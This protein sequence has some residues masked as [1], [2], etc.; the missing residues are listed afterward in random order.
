MSFR[1]GF[2]LVKLLV[3]MLFSLSPVAAQE[4]D[5]SWPGPF[6]TLTLSEPTLMAGLSI[7]SAGSYL[8]PL[9]DKTNEAAWPFDY[10]V[11]NQTDQVLFGT[12]PGAIKRIPP[13]T[14]V[15]PV[16][17]AGD[18]MNFAADVAASDYRTEEFFTFVPTDGLLGLSTEL[19]NTDVLFGGHP[20]GLNSRHP[21][22]FALLDD[23][24]LSIIA[25]RDGDLGAVRVS[26]E[27]GNLIPVHGGV[28]AD[29]GNSA[30]PFDFFIANTPH[31]IDLAMV[32]GRGVSLSAG[33]TLLQL[34][35]EGEPSG[36][37]ADLLFSYSAADYSA[38][39]GFALVPEP[40]SHASLML[41]LIACVCC[42]EAV[43]QRR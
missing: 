1:R 17:Y 9:Q 8:V 2:T 28:I 41:G 34:G 31:N 23:G 29:G 20:V 40:D 36:A 25:E 11:S 3:L 24:V 15:T 14:W 38:Q 35:Y 5:D 22:L 43:R 10:F 30:E 39:G 12:V 26:S 42:L 16:G 4:S 13:G 7:R 6:V 18:P 19:P 21:R 37:A 32:Q 27:G 33:E